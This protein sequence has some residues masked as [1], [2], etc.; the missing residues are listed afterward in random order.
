MGHIHD[1][2]KNAL[3]FMDECSAGRSNVVTHHNLLNMESISVVA[4]T[5]L[6]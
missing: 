5:Y 4:D 2:V 3:S 1:F 6:T